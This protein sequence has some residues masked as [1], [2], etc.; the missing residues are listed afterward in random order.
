MRQTGANHALEQAFLND[1]DEKLWSSADKLRQQLDAANYKHIVLGLIFLKYISDSFTHQQEKIQAELSDPE[2]PLY[3][4]RT[5]YDTDEEYQE[6]LTVELETATTTP[7]T[8]CSGCRSKPVGTRLKP[9]P[10]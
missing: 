6:A 5:F 1:L 10:S 3:L 8:M 9:F 2:N 7:P 4:D